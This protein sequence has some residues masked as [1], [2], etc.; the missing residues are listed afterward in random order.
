MTLSSTALLS[1]STNV[2]AA[3][4][5]SSDSTLVLQ[6]G[7]E[8]TALKSL[9]IEAENRVQIDFARPEL[10]INLDPATA[11][12]LE[13]GSSHDILDRTLPDF[14]FPLVAASVGVPSPYL[15]RPWLGGFRSGTIAR[16]SPQL[17]GVERWQL[18]IADSG[19]RVVRN[20]SGK[21]KPPETLEWDGKDDA[22]VPS[23]PGPT[24]SFV[25]TAFDRAGNERNFN[26]DAFQLPPY[27]VGGARNPQ[28]LFA[29]DQLG[30][31]EPGGPRAL[32]REIAS[33]F[34][35]AAD[36][37][38][39]ITL[40][41]T[42][43]SYEQAQSLGDAVAKELDPLLLGPP[44]R[45]RVITDVQTSAARTGSFHVALAAASSAPAKDSR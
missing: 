10:R 5:A 22:G 37:R 31:A 25:L 23:P 8:G 15:S 17:E 35:Q 27:R 44:H 38:G 29:G 43:R 32:V 41:V 45:V 30:R 1:W 24:Y 3:E 18:V 39:E 19:G 36:P 9:T 7:E 42:A 11:P 4:E 12:G 33:W 21:G 16:F 34:N 40:R 6:G 20:F 28:V 13:W 26:G 2:P 14:A